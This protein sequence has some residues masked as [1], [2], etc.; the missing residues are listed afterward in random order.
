MQQVSTIESTYLE[1]IEDLNL[2]SLI[3][4][5]LTCKPNK[6]FKIVCSFFQNSNNITFNSFN[7]ILKVLCLKTTN[8][9]KQFW[10]WYLQKL[11]EFTKSRSDLDFSVIKFEVIQSLVRRLDSLTMTENNS[12][13]EKEEQLEESD[14]E[15]S[16]EKTVD[17]VIDESEMD[18]EL[19]FDLNNPIN[20]EKFDLRLYNL[21]FSKSILVLLFNSTSMDKRIFSLNIFKDILRKWVPFETNEN[22]EVFSNNE[23]ERNLVQWI[24]ENK[25]IEK[26][27]GSSFHLEIAQRSL[28]M[29]LFLNRFNE[30]K[31]SDFDLIWGWVMSNQHQTVVHGIFSI[32]QGLIRELNF[33]LLEICTS[34]MISLYNSDKALIDLQFANLIKECLLRIRSLSTLN[35]ECQMRSK[36]LTDTLVLFCFEMTSDES[37]L[38][39]ALITEF[40]QL[41]ISLLYNGIGDLSLREEIASIF[42]KRMRKHSSFHFK[43]SE[44]LFN[45]IFSSDL[46]P[47]DKLEKFSNF[48]IE[49]S[50]ITDFLDDLIHYKKSAKINLEKLRNNQ[51]FGNLRVEDLILQGKLP[52][53][54][55]I[56]NRLAFIHST[57]IKFQELEKDQKKMEL[58][59]VDGLEADQC[60]MTVVRFKF[61]F[62]RSK[63]D[64]FILWDEIISNSL[65]VS[66]L[67]IGYNIFWYLA[68]VSNLFLESIYLERVLF[69]KDFKTIL[70]YSFKFFNQC[71]LHIG[72]STNSIR[73]VD[74][75][76]V[77][78]FDDSISVDLFWDIALNALNESVGESAIHFL[79]KFYQS[80]IDSEKSD[81]YLVNRC[82]NEI[83]DAFFK[84]SESYDQIKF[85]R[86][87]KILKDHLTYYI[88]KN[89]TSIV[90]HDHNIK[91][92]K[93]LK[94]NFCFEDVPY[95][96]DI[97]ELSLLKTFKK[98]VHGLLN[99]SS[100]QD[101]RVIYAGKEL[102]FEQKSLKELNVGNNVLI[103][104]RELADDAESP[105]LVV[106]EIKDDVECSDN[107]TFLP[108]IAEEKNFMRLYNLLSLPEIQACMIWELIL[109]IPTSSS[110]TKKISNISSITEEKNLISIFNPGINF[111]FLYSLQILESML[112]LNKFEG[113]T[114]LKKFLFVECLLNNNSNFSLKS[115]KLVLKVLLSCVNYFFQDSDE[116]F[117]K[118][119]SC[120]E[121]KKF[122]DIV[123]QILFFFSSDDGTEESENY[124]I[125]SEI[126]Q[127]IFKKPIF[128]NSKEIIFELFRKSNLLKVCLIECKSF[129]VRKVI[130]NT[131][132]NSP[133]REGFMN[134]LVS[135]LPETVNFVYQCENY[136]YLLQHL[137]EDISYTKYLEVFKGSF[138]VNLIEN[139]ENHPIC[140]SYSAPNNDT[141]ITGLLNL[142]TC[143]TNKFFDNIENFPSS[144]LIEI[145]FKKCLFDIPKS[146][147]AVQLPKCKLSTS[148]EAAF[149]LLQEL[150]FKNESNFLFVTKL[151]YEQ[152]PEGI[153][154]WSNSPDS[155]TK[156][157]CGFV[158]LENLGATCYLNSIMQQF[159]M[160]IDFRK[161]ILSVVIPESERNDNL[162]YE[163]QRLF[164]N[165]QES[166]KKYYEPTTLC[167]AYT[168][169]DGE[170]LNV[171]EQ[172]D[173]DEFF[174]IFFLR[175]ED[176]LKGK[177]DKEN[178]LKLN[179]GGKLLQRITSKE[180]PHFSESFESFFAL[181]CEVKNKRNLL[182]SL[183]L[184]V[185]KE[186]L[187]R[188][189]KYFCDSCKKHVNATKRTCI[190]SL[191]NNLIVHLKRFDY[192]Q[193]SMRR[194]KL[195]DKFEFPE[196]LDMFPYTAEGVDHSENNFITSKRCLYELSGVLIHSGSSESGHYYSYVKDKEYTDR[197]IAFNDS[198]VS[199]FNSNLISQKCF[200]GFEEFWDEFK[201]KSLLKPKIYSAYMLFYDCVDKQV[202]EHDNVIPLELFK[203]VWKENQMF[204]NEK[205]LFDDSFSNFLTQIIL[206]NPN[207]VTENLFEHTILLGTKYFLR[208]VLHSQ[209]GGN[210]NILEKWIQFLAPQY[211]SCFE[212]THRTGSSLS[213]AA[214]N[215]INLFI[216]PD[217]L[218]EF[219][220]DC[221]S[222]NSRLAFNLLIAKIF[223]P[224]RK[225]HPAEYGILI[226]DEMKTET[227]DK[228]NKKVTIR[229]DSP[230]ASLLNSLISLL[231][232]ALN[233]KKQFTQYFA[234]LHYFA[235]SSLE[236]ST[237]MIEHGYVKSLFEFYMEDRTK[238]DDYIYSIS[239]CNE[240]Y[241][242]LIE[243]LDFL[244]GKCSMEV[245]STEDDMAMGSSTLLILNSNEKEVILHEAESFISKIIIDRIDKKLTHSLISKLCRNN[246]NVSNLAIG[247]LLDELV[248]SEDDDFEEDS[249][250]NIL[251][252]AIHYILCLSDNLK[253]IKFEFLIKKH[254]LLI[255]NSI[256]N[257]EESDIISKDLLIFF[258]SCYKLNSL[259]LLFKKALK[260]TVF[261]KF[262]LRQ[263]F[264]ADLVARQQ[265]ESI[266]L[267][268]VIESLKA[269][270]CSSAFSVMIFENLL[271]FLPEINVLVH[272]G[273]Q[274]NIDNRIQSQCYHRIYHYFNLLYLFVKHDSVFGELI[275][276]NFEVLYNILH[277]SISVGFVDDK[278]IT[279]ILKIIDLATHKSKIVVEALIS[280]VAFNR[281]FSNQIF[282]LNYS[283]PRDLLAYLSIVSKCCDFND[284][285]F[286]VVQEPQHF[287]HKFSNLALVNEKK[288]K[289]N[290][291]LDEKEKCIV[292]DRLWGFLMKCQCY[293]LHAN[294]NFFK[295]FLEKFLK[296]YEKV[297]Y[298]TIK[299]GCNFLLGCKISESETEI[300]FDLGLFN[301]VVESILSTSKNELQKNLDLLTILK[302]FFSLKH[303]KWEKVDTM[304]FLTSDFMTL[305]D[306]ILLFVNQTAHPS[307]ISICIDNMLLSEGILLSC[308]QPVNFI[309]LVLEKPLTSK[310]VST[311]FEDENLLDI[312]PALTTKFLLNFNRS[313][314][315]LLFLK[316]FPHLKEQNYDFLP[317]LKKL[318]TNLF[319]FWC[320][321]EIEIKN[322][323]H[324]K[325]KLEKFEFSLF[326]FSALK[327]EFTFSDVTLTKLDSMKKILMEKGDNPNCNEIISKSLNWFKSYDL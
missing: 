20:L 230:I 257:P 82:L 25:F 198:N 197:W 209:N 281:F 14:D 226:L 280:N 61:E 292:K 68:S 55:Q 188:D 3:S 265:S 210:L 228:A 253:S 191:P 28:E 241:L 9:S 112:K 105:G 279:N 159:F 126:L 45:C 251:T 152:I 193:D 262:I 245:N 150:S 170:R 124:L 118:S 260:A 66:E 67:E 114:V 154:N 242:P 291:I 211:K 92:A 12:I 297:D 36:K 318:D 139:I 254:F 60:P 102:C 225:F 115:S 270:G 116:T 119:L 266:I 23:L 327:K 57:I 77:E 104:V 59:K 76:I 232:K 121:T 48:F 183:Q 7:E 108:T 302:K 143:I 299:R 201:K 282:I 194:I 64:C 168:G 44:L 285:F 283:I 269:N 157:N 189:N 179:Y 303:I 240:N 300:L 177:N 22:D 24:K 153:S 10:I 35:S 212:A 33:E 199:T 51:N 323:K 135:L 315:S 78:V 117:F 73:V 215:L 11:T 96:I 244:L 109:K 172:T 80:T 1:K 263:I 264:N 308:S 203:S 165:L 83:S 141:I 17:L 286:G 47:E 248:H 247:F 41:T 178:L 223:E 94:I 229:D 107:I 275:G 192:D 39:L 276:K 268:V 295:L 238:L 93:N 65:C 156:A 148:R 284:E 74:N 289:L 271:E 208:I 187:D 145:A 120:E 272:E 243:V 49:T 85:A 231:P 72:E 46:N 125:I 278:N 200:G 27:F 320:Q 161:N 54:S 13:C 180:C 142:I 173:V 90:S 122:F 5:V 236:V 307:L 130:A 175:L 31:I 69:L 6:L 195:N 304:L 310:C 294:L 4:D 138:L 322:G 217:I 40:L 246:L 169:Y 239:K 110:L 273:Y 50:L 91:N 249:M 306:R 15:A 252:E 132:L 237:F 326:V 184:Y 155:L 309:N 324:L 207:S 255:M 88:L 70:G 56:W 128:N 149:C 277:M 37:D 164:V 256:E 8:T 84:N 219:L 218:E 305:V 250:K 301:T 261:A 133:L 18:C 87:L 134:Q 259:N 233:K 137:M 100:N 296:V 224:F 30:F 321:I 171:K 75:E 204:L 106:P 274:D 99:L 131:L 103:A 205:N 258:Y 2:R 317:I 147:K 176:L 52:H 312:I 298:D 267:E 29:L 86:S 144:R 19:L 98:K 182:E 95:T 146:Q 42:L 196:V 81:T 167:N 16:S 113:A 290:E 293:E 71:F 235:T 227:E 162:L 288:S 213:V 314:F 129:Q 319:E 206:E 63:E 174:N 89:P 123:H 316:I 234:L 158:G 163:L 325:E 287:F 58:L 62:F 21:E 101:L 151:L 127:L 311:L 97:S 313:E 53:Y 79:L 190:N 202:I 38:S 26:I 222:T 160:N 214:K 43:F 166:E 140:E 216:N 34:K 32:I 136:F 111:K 220:L 221:H 181:Q 186:T 185:E